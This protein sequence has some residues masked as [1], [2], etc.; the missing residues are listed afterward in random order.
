MEAIVIAIKIDPSKEY[1]FRY[2]DEYLKNHREDSDKVKPIM[3]DI[4]QLGGPLYDGNELIKL[5]RKHD[6]DLNEDNSDIKLSKNQIPLIA[7]CEL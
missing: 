3:E 5:I 7:V 2:E 6:L 4:A 1:S